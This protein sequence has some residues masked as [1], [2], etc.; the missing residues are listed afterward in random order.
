MVDIQ[1]VI[2]AWITDQDLLDHT[3]RAIESLKQLSG[4][5]LIVVDNDSTMGG[6]YLRSEAE[7]Y[8][9]NQ[10]NLGYAPAMNQ[11]LR[12]ART[13]LI[14]FAE[15]DILVTPN[16]FDVARHI[17]EKAPTVGTVHFRM[18]GYAEPL[19]CGKNVWLEGKE[20]WCTFA[21]FVIRKAALPLSLIN[22][23]Y[24]MANYEDWDFLHVVR[25]VNKWQT[26]YTNLAC[27]AHHDSY[28]QKKLAQRNDYAQ[29][30]REYFKFQWGAYPEEIW[31]GRYPEQME[32]PWRPFP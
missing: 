31:Q 16:A 30:N 5:K 19:T 10:K 22:E 2:A 25:H 15:N 7:I 4:M 26:A 27:Y 3:Q 1:T 17:F 32:A 6:G 11:G 24:L 12:L 14:C 18:V 21:F 13:D 9:K 23:G 28:T 20:R 29:K 8:I